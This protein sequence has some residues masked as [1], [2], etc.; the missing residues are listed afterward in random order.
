MWYMHHCQPS[1][2]C[3]SDDRHSNKE[4]VFL[5]GFAFQFSANY[6]EEHFL[7]ASSSCTKWWVSPLHFHTRTSCDL[8]MLTLLSLLHCYLLVLSHVMC[9]YVCVY[10]CMHTYIHSLDSAYG[11]N[12]GQLFFWVWLICLQWFLSFA[13]F[14]SVTVS[15]WLDKSPLCNYSIFTYY[16]FIMI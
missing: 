12:V 8:P 4:R 15:L 2:F 11:E 16:S 10:F 9:M 5:C 14:P 7:L 3:L 13:H 6:W 1:F